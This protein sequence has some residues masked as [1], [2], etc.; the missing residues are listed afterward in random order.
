MLE[1]GE[2]RMLSSK[3][4]DIYIQMRKNSCGEITG[5][6]IP[7]SCLLDMMSSQTISRGLKELQKA[8]FILQVSKGGMYGSPAIYNFVGPFKDPYQSERK[9]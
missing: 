1:S 9:H 7:Y 8:G 2:W 5:I 4:H 6:K 3:A